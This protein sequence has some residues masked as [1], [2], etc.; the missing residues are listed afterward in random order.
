MLGFGQA[1]PVDVGVDEGVVPFGAAGH[2]AGGQQVAHAL[3]DRHP[4]G[5]EPG[6]QARGH[7]HLPEVAE[8]PEA[9]DVGGGVDPDLDGG[10][11]G[12]VVEG[13][14]E[15]HGIGL[16]RRRRSVPLQGGG[17]HPE[18][19]GLGQHQ[20]VAGPGAA[21][22]EHLPG[23]DRPD[24]GHAVF[25]LGVVDGMA[26]DHQRPGRPGDV[27]AAV[28]DPGQELEGQALS[29]PRHQVEGHDGRAAHGV[30]VGEGVGGRHPSPVVGIVDDGGE[31][32][33]GEDDGEIVSHPVHGGVVGR[34][35]AHD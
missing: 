25:R 13:G 5:I 24:D 28:E 8:Q 9:G 17:D 11:P 18:A 7:Q 6:G 33:D 20:G 21:V 35:E 23:I 15:P 1:G 14:H 2:H 3:D 34:V 19:D 16:Q 32:V 27:G 30:D 29:G 10:V 22:G 31:E 4:G 26:P 12:G